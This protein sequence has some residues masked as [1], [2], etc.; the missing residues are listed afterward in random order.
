MSGRHVMLTALSSNLT[1]PWSISATTGVHAAMFLAHYSQ[2]VN[3]EMLPDDQLKEDPDTIEEYDEERRA[4]WAKKWD[5][6]LPEIK[7]WLQG[8]LTR[9]EGVEQ[10][11]GGSRAHVPQFSYYS[12]QAMDRWSL[13]AQNEPKFICIRKC[14]GHPTGAAPAAFAIADP[15]I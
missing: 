15:N 3:I 1:K 14:Q 8:P 10:K 9:P 5:E 4:N 7:K 6:R 11:V 13:R 2:F 12:S